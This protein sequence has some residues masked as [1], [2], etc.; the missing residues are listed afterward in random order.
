[1]RILLEQI[2]VVVQC[3]GKILADYL[4]ILPSPLRV[5]VSVADDVEGWLFREVRCWLLIGLSL[6]HREHRT[7]RN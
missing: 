4:G 7:S 3:A 1:M 5:E 6:S 2:E